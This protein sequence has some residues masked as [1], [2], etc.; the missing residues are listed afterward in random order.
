MVTLVSPGVKVLV[1]DE[2]AYA[3]P[4]TGTIP[5]VVVA[6]HQ[7][8]V[9]PTGTETDGI[10][11]YTKSENAHRVVPVTSQRELVQFFGDP[12]FESSEGAETS[13]YGLLAAY[14][15]LGIGSQAYI[16]RA[17]V[18][19]GE[20]Q[21]TTTAPK[22]A[23]PA[24]SYW[25]DTANSSFGVHEYNGTSWI[26]KAVTVE[27]NDNATASEVAGSYA[28][29]TPVVDGEFLVATLYDGAAWATFYYK[30]ING[31]WVQLGHGGGAAAAGQTFEITNVTSANPAIV[32]A[33]GHGLSDGEKVRITGVGGMT[34]INDQV[35]VVNVLNGNQF[36][37]F[38]LDQTSTNSTGYSAYASPGTGERYSIADG[39]TVTYAAHHD[40]PVIATDGDV[41]IKTTSMG[42]GLDLGLYQADTNGVFGAVEVEGVTNTQGGS[43]YI[44][45]DGSDSSAIIP[46]NGNAV[47]ALHQQHLGGFE[48]K[49]SVSGI[50]T[51]ITGIVYADMMEPTGDPAHGTY[52]FDNTATAYDILKVTST[53]WHRIATNDVIYQTAAPTIN[54]NTGG[55][56]NADSIWIDTN[57][58]DVP[59]IYKWTGTGWMEVDK[60]DQSTPDGCL[61]TDIVADDLSTGIVLADVTGAP[62][63]R[64]YPNGMLAVNMCRSGNTV[65][66]YDTEATLT[67]WKWRNAAANH[68]DGRGAFGR[69]AQRK[70][71]SVKMQA[72]ISGNEDLRD[73]ARNFTLMAAPN[74]PEV[75]DELVTLNTDR[76][77]TAFIVIDTPM[78]KT[79][80][81]VV[82]WVQGNLASENGTDGLTTKYTYSAAY[83]PAGRSTDTDGNTVTVPP[84]HMV[85][86]Q[87]AY[88]DQIAFPWFA[89]AG[90]T[91][92]VVRNAST[93]GYIT[94][95]EE[96]KAISLSQGQRDAM[97]TNKLNP[98]ANFPN[99]G[100]VL[101]GQKTFHQFDSA[102]DRVNVGRLVCYLRERLDDITR[103]FLFEQNDKQTRDRA[104]NVVQTFMLDIMAKRGLY[105]FA[106][107]C[108]ESN[109]TPARIDRNELY[110]DVAIEPV[111][112][113]E[114]IYIPIRIV[115][116]GTIQ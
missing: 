48:L 84:S 75:T 45:Q 16:V 51:S 11:K 73:P 21:A 39:T 44:I 27:F 40:V 35:Y 18:D 82:E 72:S 54:T 42:G 103:P 6:T 2:S 3:S 23:A 7:D 81:E 110:I 15:Y 77:E 83:Y 98:I 57:H 69:E 66:H 12:I 95:E 55:A 60:T 92:G 29:T 86:Y 59:G 9:D 71:I 107:V 111:K 90:L 20:L 93:V 115:N 100:V 50:A 24:T 37:L 58:Q 26:T 46:A 53:G 10:A 28:P 5:L 4:G 33:A 38:N 70:V 62:D 67:Q 25:L 14:S 49:V 56:L 80:T 8:K 94:G 34:Q 41:W 105:D 47:V 1:T 65:R 108:D 61:F 88:N 13:E 43:A 31:A 74:F 68:A 106:V 89:P 87:Y 79:P 116:T 104:Q 78:R 32:T 63:Y 30:G 109:N 96:F 76:C 64:L 19:L 91:R 113:V 101:Y 99:E 112:S 102:L 85:L 97:Y 36:S 52:W 22:G 17:D 114:F